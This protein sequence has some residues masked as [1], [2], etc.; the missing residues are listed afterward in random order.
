MK[1]LKLGGSVVT[2]KELDFTPNLQQIRRLAVEIKDTLPQK[3]I[4]IHGGGSFGHPVAKKYSINE[5]YRSPDQLIGFTKTH[6][7]MVELNQIIVNEFL[8]VGVPVFGLSPSSYIIT[9]DKRIKKL[10]TIILEEFLNL[11]I[12]PI[13]YG[14]AVLDEKQGFAILS[15]DQ[16]AVEIA[17]KLKAS[18][19]IFGSDTDGIFTTDPKLDPQAKLLERI[20]IEQMELNSGITGSQNTDVTGGMLGKI[21]EAAEAVRFGIEVIFVN[22]SEPCRIY[23][24]ILGEKVKGTYIVP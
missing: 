1:L 15:G 21:C 4:I 23:R 10:D 9:N 22:A 13:L 12:I 19:I 2:K 3:L 18:M 7:A 16:L 17:K 20:N 14:D 24:S 11:G 5:G 6:E 8:E